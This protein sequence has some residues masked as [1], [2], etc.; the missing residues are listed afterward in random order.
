MR[1]D[2]EDDDIPALFGVDAVALA[3]D[4]VGVRREPLPARL[5]EGGPPDEPAEDETGRDDD[6]TCRRDDS[7]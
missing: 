6:E 2:E 4:A 3:F 7:W 5:I 1:E